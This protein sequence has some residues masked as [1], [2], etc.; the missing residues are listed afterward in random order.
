MKQSRAPDSLTFARPPVLRQMA[1][2]V[3]GTLQTA[4]PEGMTPACMLGAG[5]QRPARERCPIRDGGM[6]ELKADEAWHEHQ[7]VEKVSIQ[8]N[9]ELLSCL[10]L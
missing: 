3:L 2:S 8:A 10:P 1:T 9:E 5:L 7:S 4:S 6:Q